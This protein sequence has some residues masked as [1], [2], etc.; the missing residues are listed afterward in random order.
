MRRPRRPMVHRASLALTAILLAPAVGLAGQQAGTAAEGTSAV[1]MSFGAFAAADRTA[2]G[3]AS[4][5]GLRA[6][7][8]H[9]RTTRRVSFDL[10]A[11]SQVRQRGI[12]GGLWADTQ[13]ASATFGSALTERTTLT[14]SQRLGYSPLYDPGTLAAP[15]PAA[16][17]LVPP[18]DGVVGKPTITSTS[19]VRLSRQVTRLSTASAAYGY[20]L[21]AF[22]ETGMR[23]S[24]HRAS[25]QFDRTVSRQLAMRVQYR[26][27]MASSSTESGLTQ[28]A[29]LGLAYAP[30]SWAGTTIT[31]AVAPN[32]TTRRSQA[33]PA[34]EPGAPDAGRAFRVGGLVG[35]DR[36]LNDRWRAGA[37]YRREILLPA[38]HDRARV[39][40]RCERLP[41]R[42]PAGQCDDR[43]LGGR[44]LRHAQPAVVPGTPH[45]P[46]LP[47]ASRR[48]PR[49]G[50]QISRRVQA[51]RLHPGRA[52]PGSTGSEHH[53]RT[54]PV[55]GW[56]DR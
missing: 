54:L 25:L 5:S 3:R 46:R 43:R 51:G 6:D 56:R 19:L 18:G 10:V 23:V 9:R 1:G 24:N 52:D 50:G 26:S 15:T 41:P 13:W 38:R 34:R 27:V 31:L 32:L 45:E 44:L 11:R 55:R 47:A 36:E 16:D 2:A 37:A 8:S 35:I 48:P 21:V 14:V 42:G 7:L 17:G 33:S 39:C 49:A 29:A 12:G 22:T 30:A 40:R 20:D 4:S 53:G 28:D